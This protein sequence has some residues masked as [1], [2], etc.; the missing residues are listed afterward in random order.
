[1][2]ILKDLANSF[3]SLFYPILCMGC[4]REIE[5]GMLCFD[6]QERLFTSALGVCPK[7]A[8]PVPYRGRCEGCLP[9]LDLE[10]IRALGLYTPPFK[11]M[12]E[13]FKYKGK[14]KLGEIFGDALSSLLT[15]D[16]IL[17]N[18][19][20][21]VPIPLHRAKIRERG[22]NQSEILARRIEENTGLPSNPCLLRKK[23]TKSQTE[24]ST[25]ERFKNIADAF[26]FRRG[27]DISG[28]NVILIDDVT[29]SGATLSAAAKV[30]KENGAKEVYGLVI[31]KG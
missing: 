21:L 10:R 23:N 4:E 26:A 31:A 6:C 16:P 1:M 2:A 3:L 8:R 25:E 27:F 17:K 29:T 20:S 18:A 7:C 19:D 14:K 28:K 30:L 5:K 11:K 12:I 13:E 22:Y 15:N 9:R 24:L